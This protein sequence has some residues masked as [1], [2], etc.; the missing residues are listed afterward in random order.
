MTQ[1]VDIPALIAGLVIAIIAGVL[2]PYATTQFS[3]WSEERRKRD[4]ERRAQ[5]VALIESYYRGQNL[6][7]GSDD[8]LAENERK[9]IAGIRLRA[10]MGRRDSPVSHIVGHAMM[11]NDRA[12]DILRLWANGNRVTARRMARLLVQPRPATDTRK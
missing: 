1:Q 2:I 3:L 10:L 7:R 5:Y 4:V 12:Q 9:N 11:G 8:S 6:D